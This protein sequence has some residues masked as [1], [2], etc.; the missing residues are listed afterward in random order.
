MPVVPVVLGRGGPGAGGCL[1]VV[2]RGGT[3]GAVP[4]AWGWWVVLVRRVVSWV[5]PRGRGAG[6]G[7]GGGHAV[8]FWGLCVLVAWSWLVRVRARGGRGVG[9]WL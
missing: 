6:P 8:G 1:V 4:A 9:G 2:G 3:A 5:A 7:G